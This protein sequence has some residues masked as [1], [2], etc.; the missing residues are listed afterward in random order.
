MAR[1]A[2]WGLGVAGAILAAGLVWFFTFRRTF[3]LHAHSYSAIVMFV[4]MWVAVFSNAKNTSNYKNFYR[5]ILV[6]MPASALV[7]GVSA[8]AFGW[9]YWVFW[10]EAS[11][12]ALFA[13]FWAVQTRNLWG[14]TTRP[15][16]RPPIGP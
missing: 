16:T 10:L 7:I 12:I 1:D 5:V 9:S 2:K 6:L 8:I 15:P 13:S 11:E 4:A 3:L 14:T